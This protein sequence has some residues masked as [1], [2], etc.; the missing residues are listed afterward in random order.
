MGYNSIWDVLNE[1]IEDGDEKG[2]TKAK[3]VGLSNTFDKLETGILTEIWDCLLSH[4][5]VAN[6]LLQ[7]QPCH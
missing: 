5:D 2:E 3:T 4:F 1:I 7:V 6:K